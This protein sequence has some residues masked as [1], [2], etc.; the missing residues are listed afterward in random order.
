MPLARVGIVACV[1]TLS[2]LAPMARTQNPTD[3][4]VVGG[5]FRAVDMALP[6][7]GRIYVAEQRGTVRI[8]DNGTLSPQYLLD[9]TEEVGNWEDHGLLGMALDPDFTANGFLYLA[10]V[11]DRHHLFHY[12][13]P[14]YWPTGD[15]YYAAT[16]VRVTR[17]TCDPTTDFTTIVPGSRMVL[18]GETAASGPVVTST[19]HGACGLAF[20]RDGTLLVATGDGADFNTIDVGNPP[21]IWAAQALAD[22]I[23]TPATNVG[24]FRAQQ[25]GSLN[26]KILRLD[27]A[28][29]DGVPS[30]P[31]FDAAQPRS[32]RSRVWTLG[33][34]NP[35]RLCVR[36]NT[37]SDD[38]TLG[39]PGHIYVGDVGWETREELNVVT[40]G[41]QN[42]GWPL[43]EGIEPQA[44]YAPAL[45]ANPLAPNPLAGGACAP[46]FRFQDL[47]RQ[48]NG[49]T[50][51]FPNPCNPS[52]GIALSTPTFR[53]LPPLIDWGRGTPNARV[54]V[55]AGGQL[56]APQV[57]SPASGVAGAPFD[58]Y[59]SVGGTWHSGLA[60]P[61]TF[62]PCFYLGDFVYGWI[63]RL[64]F[65]EF[66]RLAAVQPFATVSRPLRLAEGPDH[67]IY[68]LSYFPNQQIRRLGFGLDPAP[69]AVATTD[70]SYGPSPLVVQFDGRDSRDP[71]GQPLTYEWNLGRGM[72]KY[73]VPQFGET[74]A[75][76]GQPSL[77]QATLT[78]R[79]PAGRTGTATMPIGIDN[80]PPHIEAL[81]LIDGARFDCAAPTVLPLSATVTD[82][83]HGPTQL[84]WAWRT[85]L[86]HHDRHFPGPANTSAVTTTTLAPTPDD[87]TF[88]AYSIDLTVTDAAGL[89]ATERIWM[90]PD[91]GGP[92]TDAV[93]TAPSTGDELTRGEE[94]TLRALAGTA[95]ERV[96]FYI[97]SELVGVAHGA[98]YECRWTPTS[99]GRFVASALA[100]RTDRTAR[101]SAGTSFV[102]TAAQR[103]RVRLSNADDDGR[104]A[105]FTPN[106]PVL[107]ESLLPLGAD[108]EPMVTAL[109]FRDLALPPG[110][111]IVSATVDFTAGAASSEPTWL[112]IGI[113]D[114]V[115]PPPL[116]GLPSSLAWRSTTPIL[117]WLPPPWLAGESGIAQRTPELAPLVAPLV[118]DPGF[119]QKL[120]IVTYGLAG[121]RWTNA[122]DVQPATA[123]LLTLDWLPAIGATQA[124]GANAGDDDA[125]ELVAT[126]DVAI[127]GPT[128][129]LGGAIGDARLA[130]F[131]FNLP[132]PRGVVIESARL[133]FTSADDDDAPAIWN[134]HAEASDD[135]PAFVATAND[136]AARALTSASVVWTP[137]AWVSGHASPAQRSPDLR[138][139][140]QQVVDRPGWA[141]NSH[142]VLVIQGTGR[143]VA[144]A[145]EAGSRT[146]PRLE[147]RYH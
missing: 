77:R 147:V 86:H 97:G 58:G 146:A 78:V 126:G 23:L 122:A 46:S 45:T 17:Y 124:L 43:F 141:A 61:S 30:N 13:A 60:F 92:P 134:V 131:R 71:D 32:P 89:A 88:Y 15:E 20:G 42:L 29:G 55:V 84:S 8:V 81:A 130:G 112:L 119:A 39:R 22:G 34:R 80:T 28:T 79:D 9:L 24:A 116:P 48:D 113:Q 96:E 65:D 118:A 2:W 44:I 33:L 111:R 108:L 66:G 36:P 145:S 56:T 64:S 6:R 132:L 47:L 136:I 100:V 68:Y 106:G 95:T 59:C 114:D 109:R 101:S 103:R 125:E 50:L 120:V 123:A 85:T 135:A 137:D 26:G 62:G 63:R 49:G 37:G 67:C 133:S 105:L 138:A 52:I 12:G 72:S 54:P 121:A 69:I 83:E 57:G 11:V 31:F 107:G 91:Q 104:E 87:G 140:L 75:G 94:V 53:H 142:C 117:L 16:I 35:F 7:A 40:V 115:D 98:P 19:T 25:I 143:R 14:D 110:A 41:G 1:T 10:Y 73:T 3:T 99:T 129:E 128:I 139:L 102:V 93:L 38:P 4:L 5:L 51:A 82:A 144:H 21:T 18:L 74:F 76:T 90:F 70:V 127:T 27:P